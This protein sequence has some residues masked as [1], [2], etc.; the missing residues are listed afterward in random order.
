MSPQKSSGL[1]LE[2][3][4]VLICSRPLERRLLPFSGEARIVENRTA[5]GAQQKK[6]KRGERKRRGV[7]E[8]RLSD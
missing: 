3:S 5:N 1:A 8:W 6:P 7:C 2:E 4:P